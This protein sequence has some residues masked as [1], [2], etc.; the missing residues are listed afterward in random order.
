MDKDIRSIRLLFADSEEGLSRNAC[1]ILTSSESK[2]KR[3]CDIVRSELYENI[4]LQE[5]L[6]YFKLGIF[7]S[8]SLSRHDSN[9]D[10]YL[11]ERQFFRINACRTQLFELSE[12][13]I[14]PISTN[15]IFIPSMIDALIKK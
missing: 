15:K 14:E 9:Y 7:F 10:S 1:L 12:K 2:N 11:L 13:D 3:Q 5:I 4:M 8:G 6:P